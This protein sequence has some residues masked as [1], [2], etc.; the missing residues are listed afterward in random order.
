M[1]LLSW[2]AEEQLVDWMDWTLT[3]TAIIADNVKKKEEEKEQ[4]MVPKARD[5]VFL[6]PN[7][8]KKYHLRSIMMIFRA[9]PF[10][11]GD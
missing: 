4:H 8:K 3:L 2:K 9:F 7:E 11:A 10:S 6:M 5:V 1:V